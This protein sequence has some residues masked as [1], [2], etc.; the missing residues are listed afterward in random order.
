M[1]KETEGWKGLSKVP[2]SYRTRMQTAASGSK[3]CTLVTTYPT[4]PLRA[5][6]RLR[7]SGSFRVLCYYF[8][9]LTTTTSNTHCIPVPAMEET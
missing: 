4:S 7:A 1:N 6:A 5:F 8:C 2:R 3:A 9:V